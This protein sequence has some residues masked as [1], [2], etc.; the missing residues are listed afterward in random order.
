[1]TKKWVECKFNL[2]RW[3]NKYDFYSLKSEIKELC[4]L[5]VRIGIVLYPTFGGSGVIATELGKSL[6]KKG[7]QVHFISYEQPVRFEH[8]SENIFFHEVSVSKYPLFRFPPYEL[9]LTGK[10]VDLVKYEKLDLLHVH[11][12]I[13]HAAAAIMAK[14]ILKSSAIQLPIITTLHGT[15]ITLI[16]RDKMYT[17]VIS[18][19]IEHSDVVTTVSESLKED[20]IDYFNV[21][22]DITVV[23]NFLDLNRFKKMENNAL[24]DWVAPQN[25][26]IIIHAS[27]F[28][29]VKRVQDVIK[30]FCKIREKLPAKLLLI[31]DG[32]E[33]KNLENKSRQNNQADNIKF[34]GKQNKIEEILSVGD[35]FL[36]TSETES[37]GLAAL[38]AMAC[39]V[40]VICTNTGGQKEVM[41]DGRT[42]YCCS[43]GDIDGMTEKA[44]S[45]LNDPHKMA[46]FQKDARKQVQKFDQKEI[47]PSYEKLY[48]KLLN[49][50]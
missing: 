42:G 47:I 44:L 39:E 4:S 37:F 20:T 30:V 10:I 15:D 16:G 2:T 48:Q 27:N 1:M 50:S 32:P 33:R 22:R 36:I 29:K 34:L 38:E 7:H 6:A 13:P 31:G 24:K 17:P 3:S 41:L 43:V 14:N 12:A 40:P 25:E 9:A 35:L 26:H 8:F 46:N 18:H 19:C 21:K 5:K 28:R 23:P 11:Y 45:L 49:N